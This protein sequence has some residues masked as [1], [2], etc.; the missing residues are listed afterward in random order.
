MDIAIPQE[1]ELAVL[2]DGG[3]NLGSGNM[4]PPRVSDRQ[5]HSRLVVPC[6]RSQADLGQARMTGE[7]RVVENVGAR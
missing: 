7:G 5:F 4:Q 3:N 2:E 6:C 1:I